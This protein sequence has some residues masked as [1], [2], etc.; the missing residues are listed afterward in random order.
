MTVISGE[1]EAKPT[2]DS[3]LSYQVLIAL[4]NNPEDSHE[5]FAYLSAQ[6]PAV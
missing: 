2:L 3:V 1:D 5:V 6:S 4:P